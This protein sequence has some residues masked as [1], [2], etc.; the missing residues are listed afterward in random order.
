[1]E[2]GSWELTFLRS[3]L[4]RRISSYLLFTPGG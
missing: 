4:E 1:L 3:L 2:V